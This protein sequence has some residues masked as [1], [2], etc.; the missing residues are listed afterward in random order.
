M[1]S[2]RDNACLL[3]QLYFFEFFQ[4]YSKVFFRYFALEKYL[5]QII[6]L[7][8]LLVCQVHHIILLELVD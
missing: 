6:R 3:I 2:L 4:H 5:K 8:K 1:L 7:A